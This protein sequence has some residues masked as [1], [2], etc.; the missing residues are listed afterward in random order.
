MGVG[1]F[2]T[3]A[4]LGAVKKK[5]NPSRSVAPRVTVR[6][7]FILCCQVVS[8]I[9]DSRKQE[10]RQC[11]KFAKGGLLLTLRYYARTAGG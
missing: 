4:A 10:L 8:V 6:V 11:V 9:T 1:A 2:G 5:K 7:V 3:R